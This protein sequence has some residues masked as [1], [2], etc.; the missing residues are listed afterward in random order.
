MLLQVTETM[1][2]KKAISDRK[3]LFPN[4]QMIF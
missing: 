2:K 3:L 4:V 1:N